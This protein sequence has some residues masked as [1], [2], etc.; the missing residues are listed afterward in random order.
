M[1]A[2]Y[3]LLLASAM[4]VSAFAGTSYSGKSSKMV[5]PT[6]PEITCF[7][8]GWA[9]G[10]FGGALFPSHGGNAV[11]G[12]GV[13][14]EYFFTEMFG[15]Q[16]DYGVYATSSQHHQFDGDFI[17]RFPI[18]SCCVAPYIM[19]GG[20]FST[21]SSQEGDYNAG[22]GIEARFGAQKK[23]G[24]FLDAAYHFHGGND[25]RDFTVARLGVKFA[26]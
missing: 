11:G 17:L 4:S 18:H 22:L 8:P 10:A 14:G 24:V 20:G 13:M 26:F 2:V 25:D 16:A 23:T 9:F 1:K 19:A 6:V 7:A 5:Q 3:S 12:G 15:F 21:N